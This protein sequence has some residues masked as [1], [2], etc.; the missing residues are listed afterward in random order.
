LSPLDNT[1][2]SNYSKNYAS[3]VDLTY[4]GGYW[5]AGVGSSSNLGRCVAW[6]D[7]GIHWDLLYVAPGI[8]TAYT[9]QASSELIPSLSNVLGASFNP[10]RVGIL[11]SNPYTTL[12]VRGTVASYTQYMNVGASD[13][14][15][16]FIK[17]NIASPVGV[18]FTSAAVFSL[19][20]PDTQVSTI[21]VVGAFKLSPPG[22]GTYGIL[23]IN[24]GG[25]L[26]FSSYDPT[27]AVIV[28]PSQIL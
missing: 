27:G 28:A 22:G 19:D 1:T 12:D 21:E 17:N 10:N 2:W 5:F 16:N 20:V 11:T 13:N 14:G 4:V 23:Q 3:W 8:T 24:S 6:S 25:H 15:L 18:T 7:T 26:I 9:V